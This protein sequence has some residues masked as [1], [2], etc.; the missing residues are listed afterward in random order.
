[1]TLLILDIPLNIPIFVYHQLKKGAWKR[2]KVCE[3]LDI[4]RDEESDLADLYYDTQRQT[5]DIGEDTENR[6]S[7]GRLVSG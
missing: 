3:S 4:T 1:M 6:N 2:K 5:Y 7:K